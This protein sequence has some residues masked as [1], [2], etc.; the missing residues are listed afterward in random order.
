[1][2]SNLVIVESPAKS[3]TI[4]KYL[5]EDFIV[6]SSKGHI[7]D[8][9]TRGY[10]GYGVDIDNNFE[11]Q[12]KIL[13][14]KK[15]VV[16]ELKQ[17]VKKCDKVYL[18]TD[19]DREGEAISWH[20]YEILKL[21]DKEYERIVF[22]EITK[23][24]VLKALENGR[25]ID[26]NLVKSQ[27]SRR[28]LDR[29]I[30]FS[31]S[32]LLQ[33]K[34]GSKSAGRVQSIALKLI[35]DRER[36]IEKFVP[37]EYWEVFLSFSKYKAK[38]EKYKNE[39]IKLSSQEETQ[40]VL[41]R[42]GEEYKIF[43]IITKIREKSPKPPYIT[44]TLQQEASSKLNFNAKRTMAIAQRLYEGVEL[45]NER[46]GLITYMRTDSL[47]LSGEF[48]NQAKNY[49]LSEF[50][51]KY[52]QGSKNFKSKSKN[53]QDAHEAIRPTNLNY[54]PE[55]VKQFLT[56]DEHKLYSLIYA[57]ALSSQMSKAV[58]EDQKL[59]IENNDYTFELS[60]EKEIFDG[61]LKVY[62]K[63]ETSERNE[64]PSFSIGD[65]IKNPEIITEQKFTNPPARYTE[66]KLIRKMEE[67]GIGRP[68]TYA[69]TVDTL[70]IR[71]YVKMEKKT[72]I[73]TKQGILTTEQLEKFFSDIINVK[74]TAQME[75][76]LDKISEGKTIWYNELYDFYNRFKPLLENANE[77]MEKIYPVVL[78]EKCP[79]CGNVL[80]I[81][82]GRY[83]E[84][85][86]CS[87]FPKCRYTRKDDKEVP[88][89]TGIKCPNCEEGMIVKRVSKRGRSKGKTF[90][91]CDQYPNCKTT[92]TTLDEIESN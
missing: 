25:N 89:S 59:I 78:D 27:E 36:E 85:I 60:G 9:A 51:E 52:Y 73:P 92:Y 62:G 3:K 66:A 18:A 69:V 77:Q 6:T 63:Y 65:T 91:A 53:V 41:D 32:K 38:L 19:P 43:D 84:F 33:K 76:V 70:K 54:T 68:S 79:E 22:N 30:G 10:G 34:I 8:L 86:A 31:L 58:V 56:K 44:S 67:L 28:I 40:K 64:I 5:G 2:A 80:V 74:Y 81:R 20:L 29:I 7:R 15:E 61:Y 42:L 46:V 72:F 21:E 14:E 47:R 82:N 37:E 12:Y 16:K 23:N 75:E 39:T 24:A 50:G 88:E 26:I 90:Y 17:Y 87:G 57:R 4:E 83:G 55:Y 71:N 13:K 48:L 11:P 49:I 45:G 35:V 1:M